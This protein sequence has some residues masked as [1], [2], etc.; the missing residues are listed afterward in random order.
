MKSP[1]AI[2]PS[3]LKKSRYSP[4][5]SIDSKIVLLIKQSNNQAVIGYLWSKILDVYQDELLT[6]IN[7]EF[8]S[9]TTIR[10]ALITAIPAIISAIDSACLPGFLRQFDLIPS[11]KELKKFENDVEQFAERMSSMQSPVISYLWGAGMPQSADE[12]VL[13]AFDVISSQLE[14]L[15][16]VLEKAKTAR[17]EDERTKLV[18]L[19]CPVLKGIDIRISKTT[20]GN[21][22]KVV[23]VVMQTIYSNPPDVESVV[24]KAV[25]EY[26]KVEGEKSV[27]L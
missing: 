15:R 5:L 12:E 4:A 8:K 24:R 13:G 26:K 18:L 20:R 2:T 3:T 23:S 16:N 6:K 19:L 9:N 10:D 17:K 22:A 27:K 11:S 21:F 1:W 14:Q 7:S 25:T